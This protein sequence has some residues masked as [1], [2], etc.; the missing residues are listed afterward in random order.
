MC[1][2]IRQAKV[3]DSRTILEFTRGLARFEGASEEVVATPADI[4]SSLFAPNPAAYCELAEW[5]GQLA[6]FAIWSYNYSIYLGKRCLWLEDL[7]VHEKFRRMGVGRSLLTYLA[8]KCQDEELGRMEW[9]VLS[10]ND[11]AIVFYRKLGATIYDG[12]HKCR[13][14]A[15]EIAHAAAQW[16][17]AGHYMSEGAINL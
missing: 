16:D 6:G 10:S 1:L 3:E 7:F 11:P 14:T 17:E 4:S 5:N 9:S 15:A 8:R 12:R 13:W 2:K